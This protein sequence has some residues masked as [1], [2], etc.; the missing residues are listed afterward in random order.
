LLPTFGKKPPVKAATKL[1]GEGDK[2]QLDELAVTL[3]WS[4]I[5]DTKDYLVTVLKASGE[6]MTQASVNDPEYTIILKSLE[7]TRYEYRIAANLTSGAQVTSDLVPI[8][9]QLSPPMPK[10]PAAKSHFRKG[11]HTLMTW[12]RTALTTAYR[13]QISTDPGF[14]HLVVNRM[15]NDR[16]SYLFAIPEPGTYH[17]R[18]RGHAGKKSSQ[19]SKPSTIIGDN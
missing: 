9:I 11:E 5:P 12:E 13:I 7:T 4:D 19:W 6:P 17:W 10:Q 16:N 2:L 8:E 1:K 15:I 14:K 3:R 18:V